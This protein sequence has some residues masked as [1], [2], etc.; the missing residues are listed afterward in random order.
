MEF[1]LLLLLTASQD[2]KQNQAYCDVDVISSRLK[3]YKEQAA[4]VVLLSHK[5]TNHEA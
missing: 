2:D 4:S 5:L 1:K 3:N